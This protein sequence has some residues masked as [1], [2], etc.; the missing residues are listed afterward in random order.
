MTAAASDCLCT[1]EPLSGLLGAPDIDGLR[2]HA[3]A[4]SLEAKA[5]DDLQTSQEGEIPYLL[6]RKSVV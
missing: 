6:D 5:R 4:P 3:S 1:S 2:V